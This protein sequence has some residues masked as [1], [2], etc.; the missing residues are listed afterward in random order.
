MISLVAV[1]V[2]VVMFKDEGGSLVRQL[3]RLAS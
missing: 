1:F 2:V 3:I